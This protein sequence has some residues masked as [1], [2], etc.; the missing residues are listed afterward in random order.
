MASGLQTSSNYLRAKKVQSIRL[1]VRSSR[2]SA[3]YSF[4]WERVKPRSGGALC[5]PGK[6]K[7][8]SEAK[9]VVAVTVKEALDKLVGD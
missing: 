8:L 9:Q 4:K 7:L 2:A 1:T 6:V 5:Q 3:A